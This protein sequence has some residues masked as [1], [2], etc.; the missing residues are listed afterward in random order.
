MSIDSL[1]TGLYGEGFG[2]MAA[3]LGANVEYVKFE[4]NEAA[5]D[6]ER[7][8]RAALEFKPNIIT[9][10]HC[11]TPSGIVN[12]IDQIGVIAK[13][14]GSLY[15]VDFVSSGGGIEIRVDVRIL[16]WRLLS[17]MCLFIC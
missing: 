12:P 3:E 11:E 5:L 6:I 1:V 15:Y 4:W 17:L 14:V 13:E 8:R 7:I 10:V 9:V 16:S 2:E